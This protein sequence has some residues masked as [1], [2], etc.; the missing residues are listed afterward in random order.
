MQTSASI[1]SSAPLGRRISQRPLAV[2]RAAAP[3]GREA[4]RVPVR[5]A[6]GAEVGQRVEERPGEAA[7]GRDPGERLRALR[8]RSRG[9]SARAAPA[10]VAAAIPFSASESS[11]ARRPSICSSVELGLQQRDL[12]PLGHARRARRRGPRSRAGPRR[13]RA[14][15]R[16]DEGVAERDQGRPL[17]VVEE[18]AGRQRRERLPDRLARLRAVGEVVG[19]ARRARSRASTISDWRLRVLADPVRAVARAQPGLL[20]AAHRQLERRV[21]ELR[22]VDA[23]RSRPRPGARP[24]RRAPRR[25]SRP[26]PGARTGPRSRA[27]SPRSASATL[28]TGSVG[29]K[30]SSTMQRIEWSTSVST[31]GSIEAARARRRGSPPVTT[32]APLSTAS[33]TCASISSIC[34]GKMIA[35]TS[36]VPGSP[37][38]PWRSASTFSVSRSTNS[39]W[40]GSST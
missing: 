14:V 15:E 32:F 1:V 9:R 20:P 7:Q 22:V 38:G 37:G 2:R 6:A 24:P 10:G 30:V 4:D 31:V 13:P 34:G 19:V 36:T 8:R 21:V 33:A 35:P 16:G 5:V 25:G 39:S 11:S 27:R 28:I 26:R 29:P 18:V 12:D 17:G 40:T 3:A 23:S